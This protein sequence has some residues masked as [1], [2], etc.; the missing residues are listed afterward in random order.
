VHRCPRL[1]RLCRA[2]ART[3]KSAVA[4][5]Q[6][7]SLQRTLRRDRP[8]TS[9]GRPM[10]KLVAYEVALELVK[11]LR[12]IVERV[13]QHDSN[14]ADQ[15]RRAA[16]SVLLNLAE[17]Q[18]RA[19]G[20]KRRAFDIAHGEAREVLGCLDCAAAWGYVDDAVRARE[21]VDR[22]LGTSEAHGGLTGRSRSCCCFRC[23]SSSRCRSCCRG[24]RG[25]VGDQASAGAPSASHPKKPPST[26]PLTRM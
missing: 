14:L 25:V 23:R 1:S 6:Q 21:L 3:A 24:R 17:G 20:N 13:G 9:R 22:L 5:R 10:S 7:E 4:S 12:T 16:T 2:R 26:A 8:T 11:E 18:R 15:M 19:A